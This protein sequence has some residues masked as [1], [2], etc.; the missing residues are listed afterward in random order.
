MLT[1]NLNVSLHGYIGHPYWP[2]RE[3]V[4][5]ITKESGMSR[6]RSTANK[7]KALEQ[8]LI[9]VGMTLAQYEELVHLAERPFYTAGDHI[10]VPSLHVTSMLVATCDMI[11]SAGKPVPPDQVR[12]LITCSDWTTDRT[13]PD[14]VWERFAVVTAGTG[15]K[16]SNQRALRTNPYIGSL[17]GVA[18]HFVSATGTVSVEETMVKPQVLLDALKWAGQHVGIGASRKMGWGRFTVESFS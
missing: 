3:K 15:A 14:G 8:H 2:E 1:L 4:I 6:A 12:S 18:G 16:L 10:I 17:P 13:A 5:N 7:H 11:R 9:S